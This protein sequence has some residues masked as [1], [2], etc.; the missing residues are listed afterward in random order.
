MF[1][2]FKQT[3]ISFSDGLEGGL[4]AFIGAADKKG[5]EIALSELVIVPPFLR[6]GTVLLEYRLG[7]QSIAQKCE[8]YRGYLS[9][10][11]A[12]LYDS[13][14][15]K[16]YCRIEQE[17]PRQFTDRL[18]LVEHIRQIVSICDSSRGYSFVFRPYP[19]AYGAFGNVIA[20]I[21]E[22]PAIARS[23]SVYIFLDAPN[24]I[25]RLAQ[26]P[27]ETIS[28][29]LNRERRAMNQNQR[30]RTLKLGSSV[31]ETQIQKMVDFLKQVSFIFLNI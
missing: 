10:I 27:V 8:L 18:T 20:S 2:K 28:N 22:M 12:A 14:I 3:I 17:H 6:F 29:W 5:S 16:F 11:K 7:F 31:Q 30:E 9:S 19:Y 13:N 26:L 1:K 23:S 21:L 4:T 15:T 25:S 24:I